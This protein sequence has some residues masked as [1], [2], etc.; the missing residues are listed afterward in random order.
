M[1]I[2]LK[3]SPFVVTRIFNNYKTNYLTW[4]KTGKIWIEAKHKRNEGLM[5]MVCEKN[6]TK[7]AKGGYVSEHKITV[8]LKLFWVGKRKRCS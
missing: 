7:W 5:F 3:G 4:V 6:F 1:A 8:A 2:F